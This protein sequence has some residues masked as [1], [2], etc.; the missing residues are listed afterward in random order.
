MIKAEKLKSGKYRARADY[1]DKE[2][3]RHFKSFT[4]DSP[5]KAEY[6]AENFKKKCFY[7]PDTSTLTLSEAIGIYI[8]R[9]KGILS[10]ST[11]KGYEI[12]KKYRFL[13]I[14]NKAVSDIT[15]KDIQNEINREYKNGLSPKSIKNSYGLIHTVLYNICYIKIDY[16]IKLPKNKKEIKIIPDISIVPKIMQAVQNTGIEIAVAM[17]LTLGMR[18]SEIRGVK[19]EDYDGETLYIH[20]VKIYCDRKDI[21]KETAKTESSTRIILIPDFLRTL[22]NNCKHDSEYIVPFSYG[23]IYC[24]YEKALEK[25]NLPK[26]SFHFLRHINASVMVESGV[27]DKYAMQRGGWATNEMYK[28]VYAHTFNN[29]LRRHEKALND[30]FDNILCHEMCHD[31]FKPLEKSSV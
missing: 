23:T 11:I 8:D 2:G 12:I 6:E 15:P 7:D 10:P 26:M 9:Q 22:L 19:W 28:Y 17:A 20:R 29:E 14:Q 3:K 13:G 25:N 27:P 5:A 31:E 1:Y 21:I 24:R 4:A 30:K 16:P 18:M